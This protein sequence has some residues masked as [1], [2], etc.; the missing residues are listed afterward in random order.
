MTSR[1]HV[2]PGEVVRLIAAGEVIDSL[3]AVVRELVEN[4][5]D[6]NATRIVIHVYPQQWRVR[7]A[8]NG[9]GMGREDLEWATTAHSTSKIANCEDLQQINS[10][11]FRGE[12][13]HSLAALAD[14]EIL[15]RPLPVQRTDGVVRPVDSCGWKANYGRDGQLVNLE[16]VAIAPGTVVTV[17]NLF[18]NYCARRQGMPTVPQQMKTVH[19]TIQHIALCHPQVAWQVWQDERIWMAIA[20]SGT[21]GNLLPQ[22]IQQ[23]R[24]S[25]LQELTLQLPE[26][27]EAQENSPRATINLAIGLPDRCHRHRPDWVKIAVNRRFIKCPELEQAIFSAFHRTLPRDRHPV[28]VMHLL[29]PPQYIDWNRNPAKSEIYL[30]NL[31]FWRSQI[32]NAINQAL[33]INAD[34]V[35]ESHHTS[36]ISKILRAAES[37]NPYH[38]H[39][40]ISEE[41]PSPQLHKL[42]AVAQINQTYIVAEHP[43]GMWL[44]EQHIAHERV[45]Y[46]Q[47]CDDWQLVSVEPPIILYQ[48]SDKQ[49]NQLQNIGLEIESFGENL[50]SVRT[51]PAMLKGRDD[52]N[53][54]LIELSLG[55]DLRT[56][57]VAVACRSAIRNGT[58]LNLTQMQNLLN[59]WQQTRN[60]RTCPHGRPIYMSLDEPALARFFRRHW[61]IGKSHGI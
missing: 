59:D 47:I 6:A 46:E 10:L 54:A 40:Q 58:P 38:S 39:R 42:K 28:C 8:D 56:A 50:W 30:Q 24:G 29:V 2:L 1:I 15:S 49:V 41:T 31:E 45:L 7:V 35:Q 26:L 18:G 11:G 51:I 17:S 21:M 36:R 13:L 44:V 5:L 43:G 32:I 4:A 37:T 22:F 9:S 34:T 60:P 48:L 19:A 16:A 61:V 33:N 25:D 52:C 55:G 14:L 27:P 12:A 57:Q 3:A 53:D 23:V 20:P